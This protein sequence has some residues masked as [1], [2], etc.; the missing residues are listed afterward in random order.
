MIMSVGLAGG[1]SAAV[2]DQ[3]DDIDEQPYLWSDLLARRNA[4]SLRVEDLVPVLRVDL[5]KYRSRETG[6]L[7]VGPDLVDELI[8]MEEF[9][10]GEV[11]KHARTRRRP[12]ARWCCRPPSTRAN[13]RTPTRM[14][15]PCAISFPTRCRCST[16]LWAVP[17]LN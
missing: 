12:P 3:E 8:A 7:E 9:V 5:R 4:L 10:A 14:R 13:S 16:S 2:H 6:A 1:L 15:A 17:L 11:D